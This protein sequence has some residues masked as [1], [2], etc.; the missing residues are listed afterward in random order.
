MDSVF[1][2]FNILESESYDITTIVALLTVITKPRRKIFTFT[3]TNNKR[4]CSLPYMGWRLKRY[5]EVDQFDQI[6]L[7]THF[8]MISSII[9]L[10][11][12]SVG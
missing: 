3:I 8:W 11:A 10:Y 5:Q 6:K 9:T 2:H 4:Q 12:L 7:S 1:A